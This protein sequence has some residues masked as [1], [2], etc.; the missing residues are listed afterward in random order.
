MLAIA[1]PF[2]ALTSCGG[3]DDEPDYKYSDITLKYQQ[4]YQITG[5]TTGWT[6]ENTLIASVTKS[7]LVTGL[8]EG[9][10]ELRNGSSRF[11]VTVTPTVTLYANPCLKWG[12]S[13]SN[14]KSF[15]RG[16]SP[17]S[18]SDDMIL[19]SNYGEAQLLGYSFDN[20]RL[21]AVMAF[22]PVSSVSAEEMVSHLAQRYVAVDQEDDS[23]FFLSPDRETVVMLQV[24]EISGTVV[25]S[26]FYASYDDLVEDRAIDAIDIEYLKAMSDKMASKM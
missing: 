7:G 4:T 8:L 6:S 13:E 16:Y 9:E 12:A 18:E 15:M 3:D 1:L 25:Y 20:R 26:V 21:E 17:V 19:Y 24:T 2:I 11:N 22:I 10:T 5:E 14:V 23:F